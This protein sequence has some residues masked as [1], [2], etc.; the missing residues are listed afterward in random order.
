MKRIAILLSVTSLFPSLRAEQTLVAIVNDVP[1]FI[2]S[3]QLRGE[4]RS[5]IVDRAIEG[6][7]LIQLENSRGEF[8]DALNEEIE[9]RID[10]EYPSV[11]AFEA[12]LARNAMSYEDFVREQRRLVV[13]EAIES[14]IV[15]YLKIL[16]ARK[17]RRSIRLEEI[18]NS[19][20]TEEKS[21]AY[22]ESRWEQFIRQLRSSAKIQLL[23]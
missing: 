14:G 10:R 8:S 21:A 15:E 7:L 17:K 2:R 12:M 23:T 16:D 18:Q 4:D 5:A 1:V 20:T 11:E 3:S 13:R 22:R 9:R 6:E 19:L